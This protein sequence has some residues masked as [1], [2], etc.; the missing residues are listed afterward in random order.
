MAL[1]S[2]SG[3]GMIFNNVLWLTV[4]FAANAASMVEKINY[5]RFGFGIRVG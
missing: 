1:N 5:G 3:L 2:I 4:G